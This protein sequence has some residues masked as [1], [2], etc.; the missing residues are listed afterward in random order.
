MDKLPTTQWRPT[1]ILGKPMLPPEVLPILTPD[2]RSL[3]DSVLFIENELL[4][5]RSPSYPLFPVRVP[6]GVGFVEKYP[7]ESFY[8]RFDDIFNV[9][10]LRRLDP[11]IV[12]LVALKMAHVIMEESTPGVA[13]MDP[14]YML[15]G[16][17]AHPRDRVLATKHIEQFLVANK[18]KE[19]FL[20]PYFPE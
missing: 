13:I 15:Q 6:Q 12:R 14:F 18:N 9:F 2:M 10:N 11:T 4:K 19:I 8:L 20:I 5:S 17:M 3:H 16:T 1:H 7:A